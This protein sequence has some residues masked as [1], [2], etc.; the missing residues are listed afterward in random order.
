MVC[1]SL[2]SILANYMLKKASHLSWFPHSG[3]CWLYPPSDLT[4]KL[5]VRSRGMM[6]VKFFKNFFEARNP[7][8]VVCDL[9]W[10]FSHPFTEV[11]KMY[12]HCDFDDYGCLRERGQWRPQRLREYMRS[13]YPFLLP[14]QLWDMI[15]KVERHKWL[16]IRG[17]KLMSWLSEPGF[18]TPLSLTVGIR[19]LGP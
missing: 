11:G 12:E 3:F 5:V 6:R 8:L 10:I 17:L 1:P 19:L 18:P 4:C 16:G 13:P 2:L 14:W 9:A 7:S 15:K